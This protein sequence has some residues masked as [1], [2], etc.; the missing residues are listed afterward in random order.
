MATLASRRPEGGDST[1]TGA[2]G[3]APRPMASSWPTPADCRRSAIWARGS[4][5]CNRTTINELG[6]DRA[7]TVPSMT[8]A[9][10][11]PDR[12]PASAA[13]RS[14]S[15]TKLMVSLAGGL[16][17][18]VTPAGSTPTTPT[19]RVVAMGSGLKCVAKDNNAANAV[20]Q[21][22]NRRIIV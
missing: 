8:A 20:R 16:S 5:R 18:S 21:Y 17:S 3:K 10:R 12:T 2:G 6:C 22:T 11:R 4:A 1:T 9:A 13:G 14:G 19:R 15:V 7:N